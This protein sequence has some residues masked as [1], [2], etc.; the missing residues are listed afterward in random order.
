MGEMGSSKNHELVGCK[1][2]PRNEGH[3]IANSSTVGA[4]S[5]GGIKL[6]ANE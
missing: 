5:I 1:L 4:R 6:N 3:A 2:V